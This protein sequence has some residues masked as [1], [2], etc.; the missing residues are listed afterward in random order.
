M[1]WTI[2]QGEVGR[3]GPREKL[4]FGSI[5]REREIGET[6]QGLV[7]FRKGILERERDKRIELLCLVDIVVVVTETPS[8]GRVL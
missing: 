6:I 1:E 7:P 5:G 3:K 8:G 2:S 4:K